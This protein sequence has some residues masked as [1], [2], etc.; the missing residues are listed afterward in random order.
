MLGS[1]LLGFCAI[2]PG[3][4]VPVGATWRWK[5]DLLNIGG[6]GSLVAEFRLAEI[7][8]HDGKRAAR[9]TG[10]VPEGWPGAVPNV[11][12]ELVYLIDEQL[13][14]KGSYHYES[15][16]R[17]ETLRTEARWCARPAKTEAVSGRKTRRPR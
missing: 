16:S 9:I 17:K 8:D 11:R 2:L 7:F 15:K 14:V 6:C 3:K 13:P 4:K 12:C 10:T 5:G 1:T